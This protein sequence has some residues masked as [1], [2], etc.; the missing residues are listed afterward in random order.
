MVIKIKLRDS[1]EDSVDH[2]AKFKKIVKE[3]Q[4]ISG[5]INKLFPTYTNHDIHHLEHVEAYANRIIPEDVKNELNIDE[6]FFLLCGI[7]L[8]DVGMVFVDDELPIYENK[9][10]EERKSFEKYVREN[11]NIRSETYINKHHEKL[12]LHWH[13]AEIIGK[14]AKGH[15]QIKLNEL[16][17]D[18]YK[19][20]HIRISFLSSILRLADECHVDETR[21]SALSKIGIDKKT[22]L[23]YYNSHEKIDYVEINHEDKSILINCKI[24]N[25]SDLKELNE[26]KNKIQSELNNLTDILKQSDIILTN[27]KL[28]HHSNEF[29]EKEL[30]LHIAN[31]NDDFSEFEI[32]DLE[33]IN[34]KDRLTKLCSENI[35]IETNSKYKLNETIETYEKIFRTFEEKGD[36]Q[37][38]YFTSYSQNM[39]P[40]VLSKFNDKFG[41]IYL[42][43]QN[44]R[45]D[46]LKNSPTAAKFAFNF[47]DFLEF[48]NFNTDSNQNGELVLDYLLLMS[49]FNDIKYYRKEI[50]FNEI[51]TAIS[52]MD[53][54][55]DD[56]IM[57]INQY[58]KFG[59]NNIKIDKNESDDEK[60]IKFSI[61]LQT[62]EKFEDMLSAS[63]K[64]GNPLK[65]VGD[66]IIELKVE[67]NGE[68][69]TSTPDA[70]IF[71]PPKHYFDLKLGD[72]WYNNIEFKL[73][74]I[75]EGQFKFTSTSEKIDIIIEFGFD[76][77]ND[78]ISFALI[79]K[80][81][82]IKDIF[83]WYLFKYQCSGSDLII[84][85]KDEVIFENKIPSNDLTIEFIEYYRKLNKINN[86]LKLNLIHNEGYN[87]NDTD[88]KSIDIL[89]SLIKN[90]YLAKPEINLPFNGTV[91]DLQKILEN[92]LKTFSTKM[93]YHVTLLGH[94]IDLGFG[95]FNINS[96]LIENK[97]ELLETIKLK[98]YNETVE[99]ILKIREESSE[100]II[101]NFEDFKN[102]N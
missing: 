58:E 34:I 79:Y 39:I 92:E 75:S 8:H 50:N 43:N 101:I 91:E 21:E 57:S 32:K 40:K 38:F 33:N 45:I 19:G 47:D 15:R 60:N 11:H 93:K 100:D 84:Y 67:E 1:L 74:E 68:V 5:R 29:I 17:D 94:E 77:P 97:K 26:I 88:F 81:N 96:L 9:N 63:L 41:A 62:D 82:E 90:N 72:S 18:N 66:R 73:Q 42:E 59:E 80:S 36:L 27:V 85:Y 48:S 24:D 49:I 13:E 14:I 25:R 53:I 64:S 46:L 87:M 83:Y 98:D 30:I 6:I 61:K 78:K 7:W 86:E 16:E 35:I 23:N 52:K 31:G 89:Y 10:T 65:L 69:E 20:S 28:N 95:E 37:L 102:Y 4:N 51:K 71:H 12:G 76:F 22:I 55:T 44:S 70:I 99:V 56:L 3:V 2:C 54:K